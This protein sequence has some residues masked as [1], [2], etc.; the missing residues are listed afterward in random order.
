MA[1]QSDK[2]QTPDPPVPR[3]PLPRGRHDLPPEVVER[4]Q[5]DRIVA[6]V[7]AVISEGGYGSLT[8]GRIISVA[9]ISRTTFYRH[10]ANKQEA[11][12]GAHQA[13]FERYFATVQAVCEVEQEW[14]VKVKAGI[15]ATLEFAGAWPQ[16]AQLLAAQLNSADRAMAPR[17]RVSQD[18]LVALLGEGRRQ[19][20]GAE[21]LPPMTEQALIGALATILG[22]ELFE[23]GGG[24][25]RSASLGV[26]LAELTL[27]PYLGS[28]GAARAVRSLAD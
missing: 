25:A 6:A 2:D 22:R 15:D 11:L 3:G 14:P 17:V 4:H 12:E 13:I 27:T 24:V 10:F 18:Q 23:E 21:S 5:R 1:S 7:A 19:L 20:A 9:R 26:E 8:V 28:A 16:Q